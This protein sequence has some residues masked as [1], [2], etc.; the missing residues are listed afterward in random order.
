[1]VHYAHSRDIDV[2]DAINAEQVD[3]QIARVVNPLALAFERSADLGATFRALMADM[4]RQFLGTHK[5]IRLLM[6]NREENPSAVADAMSLTREQIEKVYVVALLLE[7]PEQWT[8][9]YL[10]DEWRKAY[11]RHLLDVDE[12][13]GLTRYDDFLKEH[14]DGL[15]NE[16]KGLGISDEEKEF[17]EWRYRNPPGTPRPPHLKAASKTIA[18]FPMPAEVIDEVSDPQLKDAL[19]R[20]QREYGYF[21]GYSHSGFRKLMPGFMEGN[22]R[23]TTSEKEKVVETEYAQSIMISYLATGI[24]CTE[25]ATR[26]LPRGPSGGAPASKVADADLL[27]KVSDLWDLLDR[28]SL[29]GRALYEMRMRHVLPPKF[30]AP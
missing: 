28:T 29:V 3:D 27:V 2:E 12:R 17:V 10:K 30:G 13:S 5:S 7:N 6:K 25:A 23:L 9:R 19:R 16:R 24:A 15:E 26:A 4:L 21:S 11:E 18:N 14:A 20:W 1:M 8:E 22:M